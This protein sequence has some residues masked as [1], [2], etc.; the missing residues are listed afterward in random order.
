MVEDAVVV[1]EPKEQGG[2]NAFVAVAERMVNKPKAA[3]HHQHA[4]NACCSL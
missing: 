4:K 3:L 2:G 1:E